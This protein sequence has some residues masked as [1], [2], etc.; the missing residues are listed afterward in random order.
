MDDEDFRT[1][2]NQSAYSPIPPDEPPKKKGAGLGVV[3]ILVLI[4]VIAGAGVA[5]TLLLN[6]QSS[7]N[8]KAL[9][10]KTPGEYLL[11]VEQKSLDAQREKLKKQSKDKSG[12][13]DYPNGL[14]QKLVL[15]GT[16]SE[17]LADELG[18]DGEKSFGLSIDASAKD[19]LL[20]VMAAFAYGGNDILSSTISMDLENGKGMLKLP[21]LSD[22]WYDF[23]DL[24]TEGS[25][26]NPFL[27]PISSALKKQADTA[28]GSEKADPLEALDFAE[29]FY[30][31]MLSY[32]EDYTLTKKKT[33]K[34]NS[35]ESSYTQ[36]QAALGMPRACE[37]LTE[38]LTKMKDSDYFMGLV[39]GSDEESVKTARASLD[40]LIGQLKTAA[41]S[42]T[43]EDQMTYTVWIDN[44]GKVKGRDL[45]FT[46]SG[47]SVIT[48]GYKLTT[49]GKQSGYSVYAQFMGTSVLDIHGNAAYKSGT[50]DGNVTIDIPTDLLSDSYMDP[51][52]L[53]VE[54]KGLGTK[55][56]GGTY[57]DFTFSMSLPEE[58]IGSTAAYN[59]ERYR[60]KFT[61]PKESKGSELTMSLLYKEEERAAL[62]FTYSKEETFTEPVFAGDSDTVYNEATSGSY[63]SR[64]NYL[65]FL[66]RIEEKMN[67]SELDSFFE[68]LRREPTP[69]PSEPEDNTE[70]D[71]SGFDDWGSLGTDPAG[72]KVALSTF[73][74][75]TSGMRILTADELPYYFVSFLEDYQIYY[76]SDIDYYDEAAIKS[77]ILNRIHQ[78]LA[79][80]QA[81][82]M[83]GI[84][85]TDDELKEVD[86]IY[87]N[88]I[89][90][91]YA[92]QGKSYETW[93]WDESALK[94]AITDDR[95]AEKYKSVKLA[96]E[97]FDEEAV[98]ASVPVPK[99]YDLDE[100]IIYK[101]FLE[102]A[103]F[104]AE[105]MLGYLED[106]IAYYNDKVTAE[107]K[108]TSIDEDNLIIPW[109]N[110][111]ELSHPEVS[112]DKFYDLVTGGYGYIEWYTDTVITPD[113]SYYPEE[114][115]KVFAGVEDGDMTHVME[116]DDSF[117]FFYQWDSYEDPSEYEFAKSVTLQEKKEAEF[118]KY[119][120]DIT[121]SCP[122]STL[123]GWDQIN[124]SDFVYED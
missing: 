95:L 88:W 25:Q 89:D 96:A 108:Q 27:E 114:F 17:T 79:C 7:A 46:S 13:T 24:F 101:D 59:L 80:V 112:W 1:Q 105:E 100:F 121:S 68:D 69:A 51:L 11:W 124:P 22:G 16:L 5:A 109:L 64:E 107:E 91:S 15:K 117:I 115:K 9:K 102:E 71:D 84:T 18:L 40:S 86:S 63:F 8:A 103:G 38:L 83:E 62:H 29:D 110:S 82:N 116:F 4:L 73:P 87:D 32:F 81:A 74:A 47:E 72:D 55:K 77:E 44:T 53:K 75:I 94:K 14:T 21:E 99:T 50:F 26:S 42:F 85:L 20:G 122:I 66:D 41:P 56:S 48:A 113:N 43:D 111:L 31:T 123:Y 33:V 60:L 12:D 118:E 34:A 93:P 90:Y 120:E 19:S 119:Y 39:Y 67:D 2:Q 30:K 98:V 45:S 97:G 36:V 76:Q 52:T 54:F 61:L 78:T 23:S 49:S 6:N 58:I 35:V 10:E 37:M 106:S 92:Y 70:E 57:G 104:T 3:I 65:A 28:E